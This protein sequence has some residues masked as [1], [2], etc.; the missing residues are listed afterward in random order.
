M[1][2]VIVETELEVCCMLSETSVLIESEASLTLLLIS[3]KLLLTSWKTSEASSVA[4]MSISAGA[5]LILFF[6]LLIT[7]ETKS[8]IGSRILIENLLG[9]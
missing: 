9:L 7:Y 3:V 1:V 2:V 6:N 8:L 4:T 5:P